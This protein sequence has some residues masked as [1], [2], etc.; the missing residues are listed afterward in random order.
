M[1]MVWPVPDIMHLYSA[2]VLR[3]AVQMPR[4]LVVER[5]SLG[6]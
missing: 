6:K 4:I 3:E 2:N 5:L 1:V